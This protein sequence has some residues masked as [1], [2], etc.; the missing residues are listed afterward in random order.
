MS[1]LLS[2]MATTLVWVLLPLI[3]SG[4][5]ANEN[6]SDD[7]DFPEQHMQSGDFQRASDPLDEDEYGPGDYDE[8]DDGDEDFFD[9]DDHLV[10]SPD[11]NDD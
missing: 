6:Y 5:I 7:D 4:V 2:R 1:P 8:M 9:D 10:E 3:V 11:D